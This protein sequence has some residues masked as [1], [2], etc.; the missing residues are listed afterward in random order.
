VTED[1][2]PRR[3]PDARLH[4]V[5]GADD[6]ARFVV[7]RPGRGALELPRGA[8]DAF[9]WARLDGETT[10]AEVDAACV[11]AHG[12]VHPDLRGLVDALGDLGLLAAEPGPSARLPSGA[13]LLRAARRLARLRVPLP[14]TSLAG[15]VAGKALAPLCGRPAALLAAL[16]TLAGLALVLA[17]GLPLAG[18]SGGSLVTWGGSAAVGL[19]VLLALNALVDL[20][21]AGAQ[22]GAASRSGHAPGRIR[23]SFDLGI[24]GI[25]VETPDALLLAPAQRLGLHA[26]PLLAAGLV[27]A[28]AMLALTSGGLAGPSADLAHRLAWVAWLR[29][30]VHASPLGPTPMN[31]L[32]QDLLGVTSARAAAAAALARSFGAGPGDDRGLLVLGLTLAHAVVVVRLGVRL[33]GGALLPDLV[34]AASGVD[35]VAL[36]LLLV[37]VGVPTVLAAAAFVAVALDAALSAALGAAR[38]STPA[39]AAGLVGAVGVALG[40]LALAWPAAPAVALGAVVLA[41]LAF[42]ARRRLVEAGLAAPRASAALAAALLLAACVDLAL[43]VAP[44]LDVALAAAPGPGAL[45]AGLVGLALLACAEAERARGGGRGG[46]WMALVGVAAAVAVGAGVSAASTDVRR[47][48]AAGAVV[49]ALVAAWSGLRVARSPRGPRGVGF[50]ALALAALLCALLALADLRASAG[51]RGVVAAGPLAVVV[52]VVL[53]GLVAQARAA[54]ARPPLPDACRASGGGDEVAALR[55]GGRYL[56]E[57]ALAAIEA[58]FGRVVAGA[59]RAD[60]LAVGVRAEGVV[61]IDDGV[62]AGAT[63]EVA[64]ARLRAALAALVAGRTSP[65]FVTRSLVRAVTRV[66]REGQAALARHVLEPLGLREVLRAIA[67][68]VPDEEAAALLRGTPQ[69][70]GFDDVALRD[71]AR[72]CGVER[73]PAGAVVVRQGDDGDVFYVL[74]AGEAEVSQRDATGAERTVARLARGDGFGEAALLRHEPRAATVTTTTEATLLT[75]ERDLLAGLLRAR[76]ALLGELMARQEDVRLVRGAAVFADL[77]E[78]ETA[79]VVRRFRLER[80]KAGAT[81]VREGDKGERFYVVRRGEVEVRRE[82]RVAARLAQGDSFGE[83]ALLDDR[84]RTATVVARG[85]V[86]LLSLDRDGFKALARGAGS[87]LARRSRA[88]LSLLSARGGDA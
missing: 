12:Q 42:V 1:G 73:V 15:R 23:L 36:A 50:A 70:A 31:A 26:A 56:V 8:L 25:E 60:L 22:V 24:P 58:T 81:I 64:G 14:R 40:V 38:R 49:I 33:T 16:A 2:R 28:L 63:A 9:V 27:A 34:G 71:V 79:E 47:G 57:A 59:T 67:A 54:R 41:D 45:A 66:P 80:V 68:D 48:A 13:D 35:R 85:D 10:L 88:R 18:P 75:L 3:H 21:E 83:I 55:A 37:A 44:R 82:E 4:E 30:L 17:R 46:R 69:L 84:P 52:A 19:L 65:R 51:A 43:V 72:A 61:V 39:E 78:A 76:P 6:G 74:A 62:A 29:A 7:E 32:L 53:A 87:A 11:E 77:S 86:E 20:V 5:A